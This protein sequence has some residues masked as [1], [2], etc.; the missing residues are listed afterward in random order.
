MKQNPTLAQRFFSDTPDFIKI[1]QAFGILLIVV[2]A[3]LVHYHITGI[4]VND[5]QALGIAIPVLGQF[6]VKD[7]GAIDTGPSLLENI[8]GLL[9]TLQSQLEGLTET[10]N[11]QP[12][13]EDVANVLNSF[14]VA[15]AP[16]PNIPDRPVAPDPQPKPTDGAVDVSTT[17]GNL[18][19]GST[20]APGGASPNLTIVT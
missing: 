20:G 3:V 14:V 8:A 19:V 4:L 15:V 1:V 10:V 11:K 6:V 2:H 9:P 12:T 18:N 17:G 7:I 5:I 16:K 13:N